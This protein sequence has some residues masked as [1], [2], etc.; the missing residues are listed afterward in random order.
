MRKFLFGSFLA[1]YSSLALAHPGHGSGFLAGFIHP[2]TGWDH[3]L[4]MVSLG[5]WTGSNTEKSKIKLLSIFIILMAV[6]AMTGAA[7][8][9]FSWLETS[10]TASLIAMGVI[11]AMTS[12]FSSR[13]QLG[14]VALFGLLHGM[15]HGQ[16]LSSK[17]GVIT[18][19]GMLIASVLLQLLGAFLGTKSFASKKSKSIL[20]FTMVGLGV[21]NLFA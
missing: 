15:A 18:L 21:L 2:F 5:L 11:L 7:G 16:E 9:T 6:G 10:L 14:L 17:F 19:L 13:T 3:L 1:I 20:G 12:K 8:I 4:V